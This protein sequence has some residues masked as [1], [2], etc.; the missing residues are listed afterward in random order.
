MAKKRTVSAL[1]RELE[2]AEWSV[3][4]AR[5]RADI[6]GATI[7]GEA[8]GLLDSTLREVESREKKAR[9]LKRALARA[10]K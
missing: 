5:A 8:S 10:K 9:A 7:A 2:R 6:L 1:R 4:F 3:L